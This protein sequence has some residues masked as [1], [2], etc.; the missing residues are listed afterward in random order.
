MKFTFWAVGAPLL[1]L[2]ASFAL[3]SSAH[4]HGP[5]G[6]FGVVLFFW[7]IVGSPA[8]VF[9]WLVRLVRHAWRDGSA[10]SSARPAGW[11]YPDER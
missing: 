8:V 1:L 5:T 9:Y 3:D 6:V 11:I 10:S 2:A 7:I 4:P